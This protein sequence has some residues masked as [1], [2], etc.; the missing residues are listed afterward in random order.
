MPVAHASRSASGAKRWMNCP[1]SIALEHGRPSSSSEAAKQGTAAHALG[2][3]CLLSNTDAY[4]WMTGHIKLFPDGDTIVYPPATRADFQEAM[5]L[6]G[7]NP[8]DLVPEDFAAGAEYETWDIDEDTADAVQ[9]Y[10]EVVRGELERYGKDTELAVERRFNLNWLIGY[11]FDEEAEAEG[12][13]AG[14]TYVSPNGMLRGI[15]GNIYQR[16]G[17]KSNG[18]M[19]GTSDAT[20]FLAWDR[21]IVID[22]KH[23]R[24]VSVEA[25]DSE[26][27]L[28]YAL[29]MAEEMQWAFDVLEL[30]IVQ[31]RCP[32][33]DGPVRRWV[34]DKETLTAFKHGLKAAA[35]AT[36]Q[37]DASLKA[38][39]H[40][41]FC[42][43]AAVCPA[44]VERAFAE[45]EIDFITM[46]PRII[47]AEATDDDLKARLDIIPIL[48]VFI[49]AVKSEALRRLLET[50]GGETSYGKLVRKK[51]RRAFMRLDEEGNEIDAVAIL[52][53]Q[54]IPRELMYEAPKL[55]GPAK[56]EALRHLS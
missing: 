55:K 36:E 32:H 17:S 30:V 10:L 56:V 24:S 31:P 54:G 42:R 39:D 20:L 28:Y 8:E 9:V 47:G 33:I 27:L 18:P 50:P 51:S 11:D 44:L 35:F 37:E 46:E 29:G 21:L 3:A 19:F 1:G 23:G 13:R 16:D 14:K 4:D 26:Q 22:Y 6:K 53:A 7:I 49:S 15:D 52:E 43:A 41:V 45:A 25:E 5:R 40:C 2:E 12:I 34:T 48:N 38:G